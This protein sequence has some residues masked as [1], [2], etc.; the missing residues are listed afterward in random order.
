MFAADQLVAHAV[1]DYI[2][3]SHWMA[4]N[5]T[6]NGVAAAVHAVTYSLPFLLFRPSLAAFL[7]ILLTHFV[8]DRYRL[9][10][11]VCLA[12]N[13]ASAIL[14]NWFL[15]PLLVVPRKREFV[16]PDEATG[17]PEGTPPFLAVWLLIVADNIVHVLINGAALRWL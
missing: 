16:D 7:V 1:G 10:R 8:I 4:V 12:K 3:Q 14:W 15:W 13:Y 6:R 2:L 17:Y 9:A 11:W 5:K